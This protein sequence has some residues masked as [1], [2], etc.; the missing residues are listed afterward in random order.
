MIL[1]TTLKINQSCWSDFNHLQLLDY[2]YC[3]CSQSLLY[4]C[5]TLALEN[6][7]IVYFWQ[8]WV[9]KKIIVALFL[10]FKVW[11]KNKK[12]KGFSPFL[13]IQ[14]VFRLWDK[15]CLFLY[16]LFDFILIHRS[17]LIINDRNSSHISTGYFHVFQTQY[18]SN[19]YLWLLINCLSKLVLS[20]L[21]YV[22]SVK[23]K[24]RVFNI[25][26]GIVLN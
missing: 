9:D 12:D 3:L 22:H 14:Y 8:A 19:L 11:T 21:I 23:V 10:S 6:S 20:T 16:R 24:G 17:I 4:T 2:I 15:S 18:S 26:F 7:L 1:R 25:Y 13:S 5:H